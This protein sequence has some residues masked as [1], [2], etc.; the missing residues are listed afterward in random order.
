MKF[1]PP[2]TSKKFLPKILPLIP[3]K[4]Q[5]IYN[6]YIAPI[7]SLSI[8]IVILW[9]YDYKQKSSPH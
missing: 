1:Y 6:I 3:Y 9:K 4:S 2:S 8:F 5:N 7:H